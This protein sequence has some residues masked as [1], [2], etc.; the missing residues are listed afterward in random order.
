MEN[1]IEEIFAMVKKEQQKLVNDI[2]KVG[3]KTTQHMTDFINSQQSK[4]HRQNTKP[5]EQE[6]FQ[7][8]R[9]AI[10]EIQ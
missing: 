3:E 4:T 6:A 8:V 5:V 10:N 2:N 9:Q 7:A 1:R